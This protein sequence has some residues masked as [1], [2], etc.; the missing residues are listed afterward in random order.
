MIKHI[1]MWNI[2]EENKEEN[3]KEMKKRL[4]DLNGKIEEIVNIEVGINNNT[5]DSKMD[6]VLF[7][8][9]KTLEDLN[10]YQK[11][12]LHLEVGKFVKEIV[13]DRKVVDYE[14]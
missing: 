8:E 2:K 4:E 12:P 9:F 6:I 14:V 11:H 5:S 10:T 13:T 1:V 7:S 3:M